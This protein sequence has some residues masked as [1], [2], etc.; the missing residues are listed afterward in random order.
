MPVATKLIPELTSEDKKNFWDQVKIGDAN[1]CWEWRGRKNR[2]GYGA[3]WIVS[4]NFFA[5]RISFSLEN[6][7]I[8][9]GLL[10][11]HTCDNPPCCNPSHLFLGTQQDNLKDMYTKGRGKKPPLNKGVGFKKGEGHFMA[12]L[13]E[14]K[15][16]SL[17]KRY[18]NGE[19]AGALSR[20][21]GMSKSSIRHLIKRRSWKH[22]P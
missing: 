17:R 15:V 6:G 3:L 1:E 20:E 18:A 7:P 22:L 10:I 5:H 4:A 11:C 9:P 21:L 13:T 2:A 12:R 19:N 16:V 8:K 14:E